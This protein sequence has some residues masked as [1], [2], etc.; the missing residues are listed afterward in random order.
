MQDFRH[1]KPSQKSSFGAP[2]SIEKGAFG[3]GRAAGKIFLLL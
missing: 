1:G 2:Q 3:N